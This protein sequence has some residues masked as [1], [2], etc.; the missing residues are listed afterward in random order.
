MLHE[1]MLN[2]N[3]LGNW[4]RLMCAQNLRYVQHV[5][6]IKLG[7]REIS[8]QSSYDVSCEFEN[9][10]AGDMGGI[11]RTQSGYIVAGC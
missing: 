1:Q 6:K 3:K 11:E 5:E 8:F 7:I 9:S 4:Q 2:N 10:S